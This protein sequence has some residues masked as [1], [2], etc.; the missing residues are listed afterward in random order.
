MNCLSFPHAEV[1]RL[2]HRENSP[3]YN[4]NIN[5]NCT[6]VLGVTEQFRVNKENQ[7]QIILRRQFPFRPAAAKTIHRCQGDT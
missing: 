3:L 1:G 2:Q 6:P 5:R 4:A 7:G